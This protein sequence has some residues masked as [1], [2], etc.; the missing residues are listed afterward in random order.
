MPVDLSIPNSIIQSYLAGTQLRRQ[1][2]QDTLEQQ[3]KERQ[4]ADFE[5]QLDAHLKDVEEQQKI[6]RQEQ[7]IREKRFR[8]TARQTIMQGVKEGILKPSETTVQS[9]VPAITPF[10]NF[11]TPAAVPTPSAMY[12]MEGVQVPQKDFIPLEQRRAAESDWFQKQLAMQSA[13]KVA[14]AKQ[15][16]PLKIEQIQET[17]KQHIAQAAQT[18]E[19]ANARAVFNAGEAWRRT[20]AQIGARFA[21]AKLGMENKIKPDEVEA[22]IED[23]TTGRAD[24]KGTAPIMNAA[25]AG[26]R[27][28]GQVPFS[29][30]DSDRLKATHDLDVLQRDMARMIELI[31]NGYTGTVSN[32]LKS[33]VP[34][35]EIGRL[36]DQL[37]GKAGQVSATI[38][39]EKGVKTERDI[40]RSLSL[41]T[42]PNMVKSTAVKQLAD[43]RATI[44]DIKE[45][46]IMG[47]VT[48]PRQRF[49]ILESHKFNPV[50]HGITTKQ[51]TVKA[52]KQ[53][54]DGSW[55][56][57]DTKSNGYL[58]M[59]M[60]E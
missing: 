60:E 39:G 32:W 36:Q 27:Q 14:E 17:G 28:T 57:W 54:P 58:P 1:R 59:N 9:P 53:K 50:E 16:Q 2:E 31:P 6:R 3:N 18:A 7:E 21:I 30:K 55:W 19:A 35:T 13:A 24:I 37:K 49:K 38:G 15:L 22:L 45:N 43:F 26:I 10:G 11:P 12:E 42:D 44:D 48:D 29:I 51:G 23:A 25:R 34:N 52:F 46:D 8:L 5:K 41:F 40:Q 33:H 56:Y 4:F 47:R 20:Q